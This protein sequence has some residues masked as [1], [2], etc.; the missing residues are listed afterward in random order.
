MSGPQSMHNDQVH[1]STIPI[2][3][4]VMERGVPKSYTENPWAG[5]YTKVGVISIGQGARTRFTFN[6]T[7]TSVP[8][9][10][11]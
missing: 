5:A 7:S 1:P 2:G 3:T 6:S 10:P 8:I 9:L 4:E 11:S